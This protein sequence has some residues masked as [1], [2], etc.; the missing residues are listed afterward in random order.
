MVPK[1]RSAPIRRLVLGAAFIA[2]SACAGAPTEN[3]DRFAEAG[4][5]YTDTVP[6]L[7]DESFRIAVETTAFRLEEAHVGMGSLGAT[8]SEEEKE[9]LIAL[10]SAGLTEAQQALRDRLDILA[11]IKDQNEQLRGYFV[12]LAALAADEAD[13]G[14]AKA[15]TGFVGRLLSLNRELAT[16]TIAGRTVEEI[17]AR[18]TGPVVKAA[19][20]GYRNAALNREFKAHAEAIDAT[21][22]LHEALMEALAE[23]MR[24]D[25]AARTRVRRREEVERPYVQGDTLPGDWAQRFEASFAREQ[26]IASLAA[27][28][29]AASSLRASYRALAEGRPGTASILALIGDVERVIE[30]IEELRGEGAAGG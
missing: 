30:V 2:L 20:A 13:E 29:S 3:F 17:A 19:A 15:A 8:E 26:E 25:L 11:G 22:R 14:A 7:A 10:R 4:L 18:A 1:I 5:A 6:R 16:K 24:D 9:R 27:A 28:R 12:S 21:L 23:Q